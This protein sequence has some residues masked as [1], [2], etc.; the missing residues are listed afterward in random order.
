MRCPLSEFRPIQRIKFRLRPP[1]SYS[2]RFLLNLLTNAVG[3]QLLT[4]RA[5]MA[6]IFQHQFLT[7]AIRKLGCFEEVDILAEIH[8]RKFA[9]I[10]LRLTD[11]N[12]CHQ[13]TGAD[14]V[15]VRS[16]LFDDEL[17]CIQR[18]F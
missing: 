2:D 9:E 16:H 8:I 3:D 7:S 18:I 15:G 10:C 4:Q 14:F 6:V 5:R 17:F 12:I 1:L 11:A 13:Q